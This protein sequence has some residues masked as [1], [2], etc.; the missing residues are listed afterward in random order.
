MRLKFSVNALIATVS[1]VFLSGCTSYD[2][3]YFRNHIAAEKPVPA[4]LAKSEAHEG[5]II[6]DTA[7]RN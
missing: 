2:R 7:T 3:D 4:H 5:F 6:T 1:L